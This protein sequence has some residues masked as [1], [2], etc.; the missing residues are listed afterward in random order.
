MEAFILNLLS[1]EQKREKLT[2]SL[3]YS[4]WFKE[5]GSKKSNVTIDAL[6]SSSLLIILSFKLQPPQESPQ[7]YQRIHAPI[8]VIPFD[9]RRNSFTSPW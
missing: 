6:V 3:N 9:L 8:L 2:G 4:E 5:I 1:T 7:F